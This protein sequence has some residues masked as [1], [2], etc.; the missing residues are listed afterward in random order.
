MSKETWY[1]FQQRESWSNHAKALGG[2]G[3][4]IPLVFGS[5]LLTR[6]AE[7][8]A[9]KSSRNDVNHSAI[10]LGVPVTYECS[11]IAEDGRLGEEPVSDSGGE[12]SLAVVI[13][14]DVADRIPAEEAGAQQAP[15]RPSE[16]R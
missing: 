4:E 13:V 15:A 10:S 16:D 11:D 7:W 14:F 5:G 9:G 2:F 6:V 3:P 12:H 1:V 8:L